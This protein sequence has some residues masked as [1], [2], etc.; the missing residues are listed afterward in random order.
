[1]D[2]FIA[3]LHFGHRNI[4]RLDK[5]PFAGLQEM[6]EALI[7]RWNGAVTA[8]DTVYILGDFCWGGEED[9]LRLLKLL[10]GKKV[11]LRGNHDPKHFPPKLQEQF[12]EICDYKEL[13]SH[14]RKLILCHY[15][16][17]FFN[18]SYRE[19]CYMLCGHVHTTAE[20]TQLE[21]W[22]ARRREE[23]A[24]AGE[25]C[26]R[27]QVYNVGAMMPWMDYT[28]RTLDEILAWEA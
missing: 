22:K 14:G 12:Q 5:R 16:I 21:Q 24:R 3:D 19:D 18:G 6:E 7:A 26:S 10:Q 11:L 27:G 9:W 15:P 25:G 4:L 13:A 20:N 8:R 17:P 1:M 28:P 23:L 2:Y